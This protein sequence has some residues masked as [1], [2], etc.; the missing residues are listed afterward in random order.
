MKQVVE[1]MLLVYFVALGPAPL[2][3]LKLR[4]A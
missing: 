3:A 1:E 2:T 4:L